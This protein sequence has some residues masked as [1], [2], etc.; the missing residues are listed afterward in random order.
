AEGFAGFACAVAALLGLQTWTDRRAR[1]IAVLAGSLS[2]FGC[3]L[4]LERGVWIAAAIATVLTA[5]V[6]RAGRRRLGPGAIACVLVLAT[7][8]ALSPALSEKT[9]ERAPSEKSVWDRR[10]QTTAGL[11]MLQQK[12]LFGFGWQ[13]YQSD[14]WEYFR[15][16]AT[17]PLTGYL[18][19]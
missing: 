1:A 2:L 15:Q 9:S 8:L 10:N 13:R 16:P 12:P 18:I 5:L 4:S 6:T 3:F 11:L 7:I 19:S 17:Y 14:S